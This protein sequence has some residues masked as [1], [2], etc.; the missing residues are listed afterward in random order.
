L[1]YLFQYHIRSSVLHPGSIGIPVIVM[2]LA[3]VLM[4]LARVFSRVR[5]MA[6]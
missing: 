6:D 4:V 1:Y 5:S 3:N 2:V